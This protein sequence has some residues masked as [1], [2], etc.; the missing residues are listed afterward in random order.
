MDNNPTPGISHTGFWKIQNGERETKPSTG[1]NIGGTR[2]TSLEKARGYNTKQNITGSGPVPYQTME[3]ALS[4][5][6]I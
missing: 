3:E 1:K 4:H 5:Q 6:A 2:N